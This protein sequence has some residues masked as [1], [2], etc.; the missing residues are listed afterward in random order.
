VALA[1]AESD[2]T[3]GTV[4]DATRDAASDA[5]VRVVDFILWNVSR[6]VFP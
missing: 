3:G 1:A 2:F 5:A 4:R 6:Q